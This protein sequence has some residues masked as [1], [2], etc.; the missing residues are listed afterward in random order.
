MR[1]ALCC[2]RQAKYCPPR[3]GFYLRNFTFLYST[4]MNRI[5]GSLLA[6]GLLVSVPTV[7]HGSEVDEALL[8]LNAAESQMAH[9]NE[10]YG[11]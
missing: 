6:L 9:I 10:E 4:R 7:A 11:H 8:L 2:L 5:F 1:F 3:E